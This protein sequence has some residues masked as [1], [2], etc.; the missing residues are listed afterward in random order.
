MLE[1]A[2]AMG[3]ADPHAGVIFTNR[4]FDDDELRTALPADTGSD[5]PSLPKR[6]D[7]APG[8]LDTNAAAVNIYRTPSQ[9]LAAAYYDSNRH[10]PSII[11]NNGGPSDDARG[12]EGWSPAQS[13]AHLGNHHSLFHDSDDVAALAD[14]AMNDRPKA[15]QPTPDSLAVN[16]LRECNKS[17]SADERLAAGNDVQP[18]TE[19]N[20]FSTPSEDEL[21]GATPPRPTLYDRSNTQATMLSAFSILT[22][23][24]TIEEAHMAKVV[25]PTSEHGELREVEL[26]SARSFSPPSTMP[27]AA[28]SD[29]GSAAH[30]HVRR[31]IYA[32]PRT[33]EMLCS[34]KEPY[35][36]SLHSRNDSSGSFGLGISA[37][38]SEKEIFPPPRPLREQTRLGT[39]RFGQLTI[40]S[41]G[42]QTT[43]IP[44]YRRFFWLLVSTAMF[45]L[46]LVLVLLVVL[47]PGQVHTD[48][49]VEAEWL[50]LT[51]FPA[52]PT[53][54]ATV[55]KPSAV[56]QVSGCVSPKALWSCDTAA[57]QQD[58]QSDQPN[59]RFEIRFRNGTMP[60][61]ETQ[62]AKRSGP[63][64]SASALVRRDSWRSSLF[65]ASP[66]APSH[67]DQVFL[68]RYTD[69]V[70]APY[71]GE[72]TPF[73]ISLLDPTMLEGSSSKLRIR[74][75]DPYPYPTTSGSNSSTVNSNNA[76]TNSADDIPR[77]ALR[78]NG[79]PTEAELYPYAE[80]QSLRLFNRGEETEH[81]GFYTYFDRSLYVSNIS[82]LFG[83]VNSNAQGVTGDVSLTNASA[84][85]T[86]SQTRLLV[87]I[88]TRK[89]SVGSLSSLIPLSGLPAV[90]STA[91][92]MTTPGSF[93]YSVTVTLDRHGGNARKKGVYC[94]GL[95]EQHRVL[96]ST[97]MWVDEVRDFGGELVNGAIA[98][99]GNS[100]NLSKRHGEEDGGIDGGSGGC[101]CQW[102]NWS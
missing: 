25:G 57:G 55:V 65:I 12:L 69:N 42:Y 1:H 98:P 100:T 24:P 82:T 17:P 71:D 101:V 80:A 81:Y 15:T 30:Q 38:G 18:E 67:D 93:P 10:F 41:V 49:G 35:R 47:V 97:K 83:N 23:T 45:S 22:A 96:R 64:A 79:E 73:Y 91:D 87:Q 66:A 9:G 40:R 32:E 48:I 21:K 99:S 4:A 54:V 89:Q 13:A 75:S 60:K 52:I 31:Q 53:G 88:W 61:N 102:Q 76:S 56:R 8:I 74:Q 16:R 20:I 51:G 44:W 19:C 90:N 39:D 43:Q 50:N 27:P 77:P 5:R 70:T 3:E 84:V 94:Y 86:W 2:S 62:L 85:C 33:M 37:A 72:E 95:D 34:E 11:S 14:H 7:T 29:T 6:S 36:P 58:A 92:H 26:T 59:F 78:S 28:N 63:T 68:G 46:V